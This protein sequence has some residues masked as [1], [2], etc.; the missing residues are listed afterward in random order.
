MNHYLYSIHPENGNLGPEEICHLLIKYFEAYAI[1]RGLREEYFARWYGIP[2]NIADRTTG[3]LQAFFT[4]FMLVNEP[5]DGSKFNLSLLMRAEP[6][7]PRPI[8][9][10]KVL[11][12]SDEDFDE[13][14]FLEMIPEK[15]RQV[16]VKD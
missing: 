14:G 4:I 1:V 6:K 9:S 13:N 8:L 7:L 12:E 3:E 2:Q 16:I 5:G 15:L 11:I 10:Y